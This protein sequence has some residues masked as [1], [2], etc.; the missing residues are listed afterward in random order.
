MKRRGTK[1]AE[2]AMLVSDVFQRQGLGTELLRRLVRIG[3]DEGVAR[4][5]A[6]IAFDNQDMRIVSERV[7]FTVSY[8]QHEQLIKA[9]MD[10]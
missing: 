7:G 9:R 5:V 8:D 6:T 4:T 2:L 1:E 3:R 10:V